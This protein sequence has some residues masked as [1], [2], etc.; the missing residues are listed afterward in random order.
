ML[1]LVIGEVTL[2]MICIIITSTMGPSA[3]NVSNP[4]IVMVRELD[5]TKNITR[6]EFLI[7]TLILISVFMKVTVCYYAS[8]LG[9]AQLLNLRDYKPL[10]IPIGAVII[11]LI[12]PMFYNPI[13]QVECG[14]KTWATFAMIFETVLPAAT[15]ITAKMR[16]ISAKVKM[17]T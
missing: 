2:L 10:V 11:A 6:I 12:V 17:Q 13:V 7:L 9:I 16:G 5:I 1:G 4:L 3:A 14:Q 8:T 15:L